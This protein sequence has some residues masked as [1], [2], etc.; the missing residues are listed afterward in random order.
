MLS[1]KIFDSL[2]WLSF[3]LKLPPVFIAA[4]KLLQMLAVG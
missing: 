3:E 4:I 2:G 1:L